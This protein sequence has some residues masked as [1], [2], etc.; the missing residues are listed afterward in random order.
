MSSQ[1]QPAQPAVPPDTVQMV[2][3][4]LT[5]GDWDWRTVGGVAKETALPEEQVQAILSQLIEQ[6]AARMKTDATGGRKL[7]TAAEHA[8][9]SG[10]WDRL[11][12]AVH[13][14]RD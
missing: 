2:M 9:R 10:F 1:P 7:F 3:N 6:G 8:D 5:A 13:N 14:R 12:V 4:A 11:R